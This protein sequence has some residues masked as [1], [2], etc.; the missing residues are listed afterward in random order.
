MEK[1]RRV[2]L[3][4]GCSFLATGKTLIDVHRIN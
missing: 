3:I 2:S 4:L 1:D